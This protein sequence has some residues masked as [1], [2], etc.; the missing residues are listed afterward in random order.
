MSSR[1]HPP[2]KSG[3]KSQSRTFAL[4]TRRTNRIVAGLPLSIAFR[5]SW[6]ESIAPFATPSGIFSVPPTAKAAAQG[7][8]T[9]AD[10]Y[11]VRLCF[12]E[13]PYIQTL[14]LK[15]S[16]DALQCGLLTSASTCRPASS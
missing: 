2:R 16:G 4:R 7:A 14:S 3:L 11:Q 12:Y 10:T 15:F 6:A 8:W 13:T 5:M 1:H 9:D